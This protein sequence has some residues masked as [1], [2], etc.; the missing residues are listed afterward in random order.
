M[1]G[2]F[3]WLWGP[4]AGALLVCFLALGASPLKAQGPPGGGVVVN[5]STN[6]VDFPAPTVQDYL[7]E[8]IDH[9]GITVN[10]RNPGGGGGQWDLYAR[11]SSPLFE[12][13]GTK[14]TTD[15]LIRANGGRWVS[16]SQD[17][18]LIFSGS[19][20]RSVNVEVR[21]RLAWDTDRPGLHEATLVF[22]GVR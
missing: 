12:V 8:Y 21:M 17:N 16:V 5:S 19:G 3:G 13:V 10:V 18:Q 15:L 1:A 6:F 20:N 22:E 7:R 9:P 2:R 11:M 4:G 14:P